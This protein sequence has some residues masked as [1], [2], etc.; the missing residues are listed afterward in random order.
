[1]SAVDR[2]TFDRRIEIATQKDS[3][4]FQFGPGVFGPEA[5]L[6]SLDAVRSS[7]LDPQSCGPDPLYGICMD[8]GREQSAAELK[9]RHLLFGV[10][11]F[12]AGSIGQEPVRS[13]GHVHAIAAHSGWSP[14]EL[15]EIWEGRAIIYAQEHSGDCP[16]RCFAVTAR[17]GD[18]VIVP[19]GWPHL[20][21][22]ADAEVRMVFAALCDRQYGFE[23]EDVRA[24]GGVAWFPIRSGDAFKWKPNPAYKPST[25]LI[26]P[27]RLCDDFGLAVGASIF[28]QFDS[29]PDSLQWVSQPGLAAEEWKNFSPLGAVE[30]TCTR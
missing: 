2:S 22:N 4:N 26:G 21:V 29:N 7:L 10:V 8:V 12:A 3:L 15:F 6:R 25:L 5:E 28:E 27:P 9:R 13:Q 14:P 17:P 23:Y 1:M 30:E 11:A 24:R 18:H 16:G 19:P 20:V